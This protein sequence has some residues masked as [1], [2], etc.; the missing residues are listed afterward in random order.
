MI[1][2]MSG[3]E[4][5]GAILIYL[6]L[7]HMIKVLLRMYKILRL[8]LEIRIKRL[9]ILLVCR[10]LIGGLA[11]LFN[12]KRTTKQA[13]CSISRLRSCRSRHISSSLIDL[14]LRWVIT[15]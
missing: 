10:V 3:V 4:Y 13:S 1:L 6:F 5:L 14:D 12:D 9:V 8:K 2:E 11:Y 15:L 7:I